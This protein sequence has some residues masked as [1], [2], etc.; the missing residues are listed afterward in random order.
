MTQ[1]GETSGTSKSREAS[2]KSTASRTSIDKQQLVGMKIGLWT[3]RGLFLHFVPARLWSAVSEGVQHISPENLAMSQRACG[4]VTRKAKQQPRSPAWRYRL[5]PSARGK[6][7]RTRPVKSQLK[8]QIV[9]PF[10]LSLENVALL[11]GSDP[12]A[13]RGDTSI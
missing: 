12:D 9:K 2:A 1:E 13:V 7:C 4:R 10:K 8:F 11:L 3:S 6:A 5:L